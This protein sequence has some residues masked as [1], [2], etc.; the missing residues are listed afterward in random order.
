[1]MRIIFISLAFH[2][3]A[4]AADTQA[5]LISPDTQSC[6]TSYASS[7]RFLECS[8]DM[9]QEIKNLDNQV[10]KTPFTD[11]KA[12]N[13]Q[14]LKSQVPESSLV[15]EELF[16]SF[17]ADT[18]DMAL[19][20]ASI[21]TVESLQ[22]RDRYF[23]ILSNM[24]ES[25]TGLYEAKNGMSA[26]ISRKFYSVLNYYNS[27]RSAPNLSAEEKRYYDEMVQNIS[28]YQELRTQF[29]AYAQSK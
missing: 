9:I 23:T 10:Q 28:S 26:T 11:M 16:E 22:F 6:S 15:A 14:R 29:T 20:L 12:S 17:T 8:Q 25:L 1:M 24:R 2:I 21:D 13:T 18:E 19:Q 3:T 4:M 27:D 7:D 5:A